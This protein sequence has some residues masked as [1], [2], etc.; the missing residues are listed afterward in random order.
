MVHGLPK[1]PASDIV[2]ADCLKGKQHRESLPKRSTWRA[3]EK[4]ELVHADLCGPITPTSNSHKRYLLCFIDDFSRKTWSYL[5][6]EKSEAF[7]S[8]KYLKSY[9]EKETGLSIKC[10]RTDRG[11]E[12]TS[13]EFNDFCRKNGIKRQF[14][15]AYTPQQ[16]GVTER[17]NRTVMNMVRC[18]LSEKRIPKT[19]WPEA[20]NWAIYVLNRCP[21]LVVKDA[22][23]QE[24]WSGVKPSVEHLKVFWCVCH[25][26][27]PD[28]RRTKLEDK[29]F[30]CV[31]LGVSEESKD[32]K[33]Y[34]PVG[35]K[36]LISRDV[37][38]EENKSWEWDR[39]YNDQVL[40]DLEW[41]ENEE[42]LSDV[43]ESESDV[44]VNDDVEPSPTSTEG[45]SSQSSL[46]S[47]EERNRRS[48]VWMQDYVSGEGLSE[49]TMM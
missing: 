7:T 35:K 1:L 36:I 49:E 19:F 46:S 20:A 28:V 21:T 5:L 45:P 8:F 15:T 47:N 23:P 34:D 42:Q 6:T 41:G 30:S 38:F 17:K 14:T 48:P 16:N 2:C 37:V 11:G 43:E 40:V 12:F 44:E 39:S 25:I 33:L 31:F 27:V 29:S 22:T 3:S 32:Y 4:L 13:G 10:L 18:M 26:H 24:A 9:M